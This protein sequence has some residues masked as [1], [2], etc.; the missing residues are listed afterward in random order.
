M[1]RAIITPTFKKHFCFIKKYLNSFDKYLL[2]RDFPICF[3][4]A[5]SEN[6]DFEKL[7][8]KYKKSLNIKV[9]F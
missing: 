6:K 4:I 8:S 9:F 3:I 5:K 2:D 7:I 1:R